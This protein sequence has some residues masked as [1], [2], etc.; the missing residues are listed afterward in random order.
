[1][2]SRPGQEGADTMRDV[3]ETVLWATI[4]VMV[5]LVTWVMAGGLTSLVRL[6]SLVKPTCLLSP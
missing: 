2:L 3:C 6:T 4:A 5:T 1:M